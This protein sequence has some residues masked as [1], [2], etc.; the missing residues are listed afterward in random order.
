MRTELHIRTAIIG[1]V[2]LAGMSGCRPKQEVVGMVR[3]SRSERPIAGVHLTLWRGAFG[4]RAERIGEHTTDS[5]GLF[6]FAR[7]AKVMERAR[8]HPADTLYWLEVR[9]TPRNPAR[10]IPMTGY[11]GVFDLRLKDGLPPR[12][13]SSFRVADMH[14]H[15][16]MRIHNHFAVDVHKDA[17]GDTPDT[18]PKDMSWYRDQH[19]L[20]TWRNG[21]WRKAPPLQ[22]TKMEHAIEHGGDRLSA[23]AD[24]LEKGRV[25]AKSGNN[26]FVMHNQATHPHIRNGH[27][28]LAYNA[29]SPFENVLNTGWA[30]RVLGGAV[31]TGMKM[32]WSHRIGGDVDRTEAITHWEDFRYEHGLMAAQ[33]R[34]IEGMDWRFLNEGC[35]LREDTTSSFV[36]MAVEGGHFLQDDLFPNKTSVDLENRNRREQ[37]DLIAGWRRLHVGKRLDAA[38]RA[39]VDTV[40]ALVERLKAPKPRPASVVEQ[41]QKQELLEDWEMQQEALRKDLNQAVD[42]ALAGELERNIA[43]V[44]SA[45]CDPPIH[46]VAIAHLAYNGMTGHAPALD[47]GGNFVSWLATK[48][49]NLRLSNDPSYLKQWSRLYFTVPGVNKFGKLMIK[50]LAREVDGRRVLIDLK[51]S[52][53]M[54]RH[55]FYDSIMTDHQLPPIC[56]HCAVTGMSEQYWSPFNNE[57]NLLKDPLVRTYYPFGINLYD[58]EIVLIHRQR[59]IIGLPLEQ[60]LLGGYIKKPMTWNMHI[61]AK[62]EHKP[63]RRAERPHKTKRWE[64]TER[65]VLWLSL[66]DSTSDSYDIPAAQI[67]AAKRYLAVALDSSMRYLPDT[68]RAHALT[69]TTQDFISAAPFMQNLF[70]ILDVMLKDTLE[71]ANGTPLDPAGVLRSVWGR[72]CLG[73]DMDGLIDPIDLVPTASEYPLFRERLQQ[74]IPLFL[75]FRQWERPPLIDRAVDRHIRGLDEYTCRGFDLKA[76]L[77]GL[78]YRNLLEFTVQHTQKQ[79]APCD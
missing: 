16:S 29:I 21:G 71:R 3:G 41:S 7:T 68:G 11:R 49:Y 14:Y 75:Y 65:L 78:F 18:I 60:R 28:D 64:H 31:K 63:A 10:Q 33:D 26:S 70:Y 20:R 1:A 48:L 30:T 56:S 77:D 9:A 58:E 55:Y 38:Q 22:W 43:Y 51:H 50:G 8:K 69:I 25:R 17:R 6:G 24:A 12:A 5:T 72:I 13:D 46:M 59:G 39:S 19:K 47:D 76:A 37:D 45:E 34:S 23:Y 57:Y 15:V 62:G 74:F 52:D 27:V 4:E 44:R 36:V 53:L 2:L 54:T 42:N 79:Q 32:K 61:T 35:E 40:L 66:A 67:A 73:S